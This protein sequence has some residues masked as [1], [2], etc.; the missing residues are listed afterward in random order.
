MCARVTTID[1]HEIMQWIKRFLLAPRRALVPRFNIA[2]STEILTV[3]RQN[4]VAEIAYMRWG[5]IPR[6][7]KD[8][9]IGNKLINARSETAFEKPAFRE[10]ARR[11]RA[12]IVVDGFYEWRRNG[13]V[14][15]PYHI[16][17]RGR[18]AFGIASIWDGWRDETGTTIDTCSLL[19]TAPNSL[20]EPIH[21]RM[22]VIL[23]ASRL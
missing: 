14:K 11:R 3:R 5:L 13:R 21:N 2:P 9:A 10:S 17:M 20:M 7:A 1:T 23:A 8:A 16:R 6:W 4:G 15:Q 18:S 22:P 12:I 19:T